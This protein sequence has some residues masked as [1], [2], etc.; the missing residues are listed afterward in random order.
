MEPETQ[1]DIISYLITRELRLGTW[2]AEFTCR[3]C[4]STSFSH[5]SVNVGGAADVS[6]VLDLIMDESWGNGD[7]LYFFR[8]YRVYRGCRY[9]NESLA[10]SCWEQE[11]RPGHH[12][13][14]HAGLSLWGWKGFG[15]EMIF[16]SQEFSRYTHIKSPS[17]GACAKAQRGKA[18]C[19]FGEFQSAWLECGYKGEK[20]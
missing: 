19:I 6:Q 9:E 20:W 12:T 8:D 4:S 7:V 15:E 14:A 10:P 1:C 13:V 11:Q 16:Q 17:P 3:D 18:A 2:P 5:L